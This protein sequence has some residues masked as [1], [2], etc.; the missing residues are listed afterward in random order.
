MRLTFIDPRVPIFAGISPMKLL[1]RSNSL[2]WS[3]QAQ[4]SSGMTLQEDQ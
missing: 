4:T 2:A 3:P 1:L